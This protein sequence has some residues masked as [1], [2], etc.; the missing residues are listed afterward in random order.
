MSF[1]ANIKYLLLI[2][3]HHPYAES[4]R[5]DHHHNN[6][7]IHPIKGSMFG[8]I[9]WDNRS[10]VVKPKLKPTAIYETELD[11]KLNKSSKSKINL[12]GQ[13]VGK[14]TRLRPCFQARQNDN[15]TFPTHISP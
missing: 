10:L 2:V 1:G 15:I 12:Y 3:P 5:V 9:L 11:S 8:L 7:D 14:D 4:L 13:L 6:T